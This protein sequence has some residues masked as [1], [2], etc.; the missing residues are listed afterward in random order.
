MSND[1]VM[2][3]TEEQA[4]ARLRA[5]RVRKALLVAPAVVEHL[6]AL[7]RPSDG[8][9]ERGVDVREESTPLLTWIADD[10]DAVYTLLV[11]WVRAWSLALNVPAPSSTV[12]A[13]RRY[14]LFDDGTRGSNVLGFPAWV[15]PRNARDL[16]SAASRWLSKHGDEIERDPDAAAYQDDVANAVWRL[17]VGYGLLDDLSIARRL[18]TPLGRECPKCHAEAV[19]AEFFGGS[20]TAAELRGE[21]LLEEWRGIEVR[22][23]ACTWVC[24]PRAG[25]LARWLK[26]TAT[27]ADRAVRGVDTR[28]P[29]WTVDQAAQHLEVSRGAIQKYIREGL[30]TYRLDDVDEV[31]VK[32]AEVIEERR[33][34][35][36]QKRAAQ[37]RN[38]RRGTSH[39]EEKP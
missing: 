20:L 11:E 9:T 19:H 8:R 39:Y 28:M 22:C 25:E 5:A 29:F 2:E 7:T 34:R 26:G 35:R 14:H 6:R 4:A 30:P 38:L 36:E 16:V 27:R 1:D 24:E 10:A 3:L 37:G 13:W 33:R 15:T 32:P 23:A 18:E 12:I 21:A 31:L 17:R